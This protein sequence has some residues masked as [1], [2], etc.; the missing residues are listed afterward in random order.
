M[1]ASPLQVGHHSLTSE[2]NQCVVLVFTPGGIWCTQRNPT[3][4][5]SHRANSTFLERP[6]P[7][8]KPET[9]PGFMKSVRIH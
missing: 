1:I 9:F 6:A 2:G 8:I 7:A 5:L 4:A 3:R